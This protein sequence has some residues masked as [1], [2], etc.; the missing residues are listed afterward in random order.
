MKRRDTV[1][2]GK[3]QRLALA[4]AAAADPP[5]S[6]QEWQVL[7]T[8]VVTIGSWDR[9]TDHLTL[10]RIADLAGIRRSGEHHVREEARAVSKA[11]GRLAKL[12]CLAYV[13]SRPGRPSA[14]GYRPGFL[15]LPIP[16]EM[17][18][19]ADPNTEEKWGSGDGRNRGLEGAEMG[20]AET[21][22][23]GTSS[24]SKYPLRRN[25]ASPTPGRQ[26]PPVWR[27]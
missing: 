9:L 14:G 27:T 7:T 6:G 1:A 21:P 16:P 4:R 8:V 10:N 15:A 23:T 25:G 11:L 5:L 2:A 18:D 19:S 12:G 17:G 13:A 20:S 22:P 3:A 26:G 24:V